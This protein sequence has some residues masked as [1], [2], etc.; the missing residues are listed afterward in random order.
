MPPPIRQLVNYCEAHPIDQHPFL[1]WGASAP[2]PLTKVYD[3]LANAYGL[4]VN[5]PPWLAGVISQLDD[6]RIQSLLAKQL[7][8]ELGDGDPARMHLVLY[9]RALS[10]LAPFR[11][12]LPAEEA[13]APGEK[14]LQSAELYFCSSNPYEA[15]G[16]VMAGEVYGSQFFAWLGTALTRQ[17]QVD[18]SS[19]DWY[20]AHETLEAEHAGDSSVIGELVADLPARREAV[21]RGAL[22]IDWVIKSFLDDLHRRYVVELP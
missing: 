18:V 12:A 21:W 20:G 4:A 16:A 3:I 11:P 22:G 10:L 14:F 2:E 13:T 9:Q 7:N 8:G 15:L 1:T 19:L 6:R 17:N 5:F